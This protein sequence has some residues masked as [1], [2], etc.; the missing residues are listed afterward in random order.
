MDKLWLHLLQNQ[1]RVLNIFPTHKEDFKYTINKFLPAT[2][3]PH[4]CLYI[5]LYTFQQLTTFSKLYLLLSFNANS[6]EHS[7]LFIHLFHSSFVLLGP[8]LLFRSFSW[9]WL[10][11]NPR[12]VRFHC[13]GSKRY[14]HP[15]TNQARSP[16]K[17]R[18]GT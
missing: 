10:L 2:N 8:T 5:L 12:N 18:L 6:D 13:L 1:V 4:S 11:F 14:L 15:W 16:E 7:L 9:I 3:C 17:Y